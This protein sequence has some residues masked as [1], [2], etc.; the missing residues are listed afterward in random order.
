VIFRYIMD[1]YQCGIALTYA[2]VRDMTDRILAARDGGQVG[3]Q[4]PCK[5]QVYRQSH[6]TF[7]P[8]VRQVESFVR[9]SC[10]D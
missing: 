5:F 6:D 10:V 1:M 4:R 2:A 9:E 7:Q 8:I 3:I